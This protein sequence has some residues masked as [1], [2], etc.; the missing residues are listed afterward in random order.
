M[1]HPVIRRAFEYWASKRRN[2]R[3]PRRSDIDP[4]EIPRLLPHLA[5]VDLHAHP[6]GLALSLVGEHLVRGAGRE[7]KGLRIDYLARESAAMQA[8]CT[9][10]TTALATGAPHFVE[11]PVSTPSGAGMRCRAVALPL[12]AGDSAEIRH[13]LFAAVLGDD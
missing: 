11:E 13:I 12:A 6:I 9:A 7:L 3:P 4:I 8:W 1:D 10:M 5:L 2:G